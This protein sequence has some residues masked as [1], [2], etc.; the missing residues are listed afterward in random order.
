VFLSCPYLLIPPPLLPPLLLKLL[1]PPP[2]DLV[3]EPEPKLELL[4][5]DL[6]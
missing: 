1:P 3:V 5:E 6:L 2:V 4:L